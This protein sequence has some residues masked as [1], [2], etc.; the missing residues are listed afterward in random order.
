M[1]LIMIAMALPV[2]QYKG[3]V[4]INKY[5]SGFRRKFQ[6]DLLS[7]SSSWKLPYCYG[8]LLSGPKGAKSRSGITVISMQ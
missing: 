2:S 3:Q 7:K 5:R 1:P 8:A 4:S 6:P